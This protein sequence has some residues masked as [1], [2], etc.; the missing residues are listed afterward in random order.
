MKSMD[1]AMGL[2]I[3]DGNCELRIG[4]DNVVPVHVDEISTDGYRKE[5]SR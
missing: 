2:A 1:L 4:D 3:T 5:G